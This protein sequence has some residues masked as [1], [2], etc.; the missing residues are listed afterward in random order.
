MFPS[1]TLPVCDYSQRFLG[2]DVICIFS[3]VQSNCL[4]DPLHMCKLFASNMSSGKECHKFL[5][6][7]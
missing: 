4:V 7:M 5:P 1:I 3:D 6:L 2:L